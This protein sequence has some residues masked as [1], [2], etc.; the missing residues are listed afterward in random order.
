MTTI[1]HLTTLQLEALRD[2]GLECWPPE[3][4]PQQVLA[5]IFGL[6]RAGLVWRKHGCWTITEAGEAALAQISPPQFPATGS[7]MS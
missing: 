6:E 3:R 1:P 4:L 7:K 5:L 2:M